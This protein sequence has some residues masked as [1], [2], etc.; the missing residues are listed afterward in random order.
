MI[1][2]HIECSQCKNSISTINIKDDTIYRNCVNCKSLFTINFKSYI[3]YNQKY[4]VLQ[5]HYINDYIR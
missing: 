1:C 2:Y 4:I 3:V 5:M